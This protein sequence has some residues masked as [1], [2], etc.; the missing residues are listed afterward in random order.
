MKGRRI[1]RI[2]GESAVVAREVPLESEARF[3]RA[4]AAEHPEGP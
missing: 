2:S 1:L 4:I 3:H